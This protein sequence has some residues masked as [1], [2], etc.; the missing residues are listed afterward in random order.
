M[1]EK[2]RIPGSKRELS[3]VEI[4]HFGCGCG[5]EEELLTVLYTRCAACGLFWPT[6]CVRPYVHRG[7]SYKNHLH[8]QRIL[9]DRRMSAIAG[10]SAEDGSSLCCA[11]RNLKSRC[12]DVYAIVVGSVG[13]VAMSMETDS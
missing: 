1:S 4:R 11:D 3:D 10:R 9:L 7:R 5:C 8:Y 2:A 6:A 12:L 13:D